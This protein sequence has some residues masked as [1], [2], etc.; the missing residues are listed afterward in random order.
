MKIINFKKIK[1]L[2]DRMTPVVRAGNR[3]VVILFAVTISSILLAIALGVLDIAFKEVKFGTSA[4]D[5][6]NA[7]FAADSGIEKVLFLDKPPSAYAT[8]SVP[9]PVVVPYLGSSGV[10]CAKV[11]IT[12]NA[13]GTTNVIS[14]GYNIGDADGSCNSTNPDRIERQIEV[15]Y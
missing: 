11:S 6:N 3:G 14:K 1:N 7:F 2:P 9:P 5:S 13:D 15:N 4:K 12:K 8:P 10:S